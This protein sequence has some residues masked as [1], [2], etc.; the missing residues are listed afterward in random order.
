MKKNIIPV[1]AVC[2]NI[3]LVSCSADPAP[4]QFDELS[5]KISEQ[6]P[7]S[8]TIIWDSVENAESYTVLFQEKETTVTSET[9][10]FSGLVPG[11]YTVQVKA[12][13]DGKR[14]SDSG[15]NSI[16]ITLT[17]EKLSSPLLSE[18]Q[19][20]HTSFEIIWRTVE[21]ADA[22]TVTW[23]E[24]ETTTKDTSIVF[25]GV[26]A[27]E[28]TVSVKAVSDSPAY[29]AS[30]EAVITVTVEEELTDFS[31]FGTWE[32]TSSDTFVWNGQTIVLSG[33]PTTFQVT[34]EENPENEYGILVGGWLVDQPEYKFNAAYDSKYKMAAFY[35][36]QQ[37]GETNSNGY[38]PY[39]CGYAQLEDG[40]LVLQNNLNPIIITN[41]ED[42]TADVMCWTG[43]TG[44][45][46]DYTVAG[47]GGFWLGK[48]P[49]DVA[50]GFENL[51]VGPFTMKKISASVK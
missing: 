22:Y 21:N 11:E 33:E 9:A 5:L 2:L 50:Y 47:Y 20:D 36:L 15:W 44:D 29:S 51:P 28:H 32:V 8:F 16:D 12:D 25:T 30:D 7:T 1:I 18:G 48:N 23:L 35:N 45:G 24:Q 14:F 34:F 31:F 43:T 41:K 40:Y 19:K 39:L 38:T 42:G 17:A 46:E 10:S 49:E 6:S 37:S 27:G 3:I 26:T 4:L 13:G